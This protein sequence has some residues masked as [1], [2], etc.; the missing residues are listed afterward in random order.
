MTSE[1]LLV[2]IK[3]SFAGLFLHSFVLIMVL[4]E[5]IKTSLKYT[6]LMFIMTIPLHKFSH[7]MPC[8]VTIVEIFSCGVLFQFPEE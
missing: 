8:L 5:F 2:F 3:Q 6:I 7:N 1:L 4:F